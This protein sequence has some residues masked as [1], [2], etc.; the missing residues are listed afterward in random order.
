MKQKD[1]GN[2]AGQCVVIQFP[3]QGRQ[4]GEPAAPPPGSDALVDGDFE[5][6]FEALQRQVARLFAD[7]ILPVSR[8]R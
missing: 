8:E 3:G 7:G 1:D 5:V 6:E 4:A 2:N